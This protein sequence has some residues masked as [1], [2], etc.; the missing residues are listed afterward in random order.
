VQE[1]E[2]MVQKANAS[3]YPVKLEWIE[4]KSTA[5]FIIQLRINGRPVVEGQGSAKQGAKEAAAQ[6]AYTKG[7]MFQL[8]YQL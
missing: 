1:I 5:P 7:R 2:E 3:A 4:R 6:H 8:L